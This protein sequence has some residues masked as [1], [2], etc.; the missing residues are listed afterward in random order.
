MTESVRYATIKSCKMLELKLRFSGSLQVFSFLHCVIDGAQIVLATV[1]FKV[2]FRER[3]VKLSQNKRKVKP[4]HEAVGAA[5]K[6]IGSKK[7]QETRLPKCQ[8]SHFESEEPEIL[9]AA[10]YRWGPSKIV[11]EVEDLVRSGFNSRAWGYVDIEKQATEQC[12]RH[13]KLTEKLENLTEDILST[14]KLV[15]FGFTD[16]TLAGPQHILPTIWHLAKVNY[17]ENTLE[18]EAQTGSKIANIVVFK[19]PEKPSKFENNN[20]NP[21]NKSSLKEEYIDYVQELTLLN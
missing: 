6:R 2:K 7:I 11:E 4:L 1:I 19:A 8:Y 16:N 20:T 14:G 13:K 3:A 17:G 15:A 10:R 12:R 9:S 5:A 18:M 21:S